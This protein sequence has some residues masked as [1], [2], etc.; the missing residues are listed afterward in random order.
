MSDEAVKTDW[1]APVV[2]D[3]L[4]LAFPANALDLMPT[5]EECKTGL[6]ELS[7]RNR[8]KWM[9]F[10]S[11]W[12]FKGLPAEVSFKARRGIDAETAYRHLSA[13]LG[14]FAPKHEHKEEAV[15][16]L[17]SR[18]LRTVPRGEAARDAD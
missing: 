4:T 9:G 17:A 13:I 14:S 10:V 7:D 8:R 6:A 2:L 16:W 3:D 11:D 12:F 18:W 1:T 15:A 5:R